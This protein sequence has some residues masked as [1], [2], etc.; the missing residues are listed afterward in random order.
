MFVGP[1]G[2]MCENTLQI[3]VKKYTKRGGCPV[4]I[5]TIIKIHLEMPAKFSLPTQY[6]LTFLM[7]LG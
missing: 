1:T 2:F 7:L 5:I 6:P 4:T 3:T